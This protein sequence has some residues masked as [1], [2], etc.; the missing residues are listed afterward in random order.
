MKMRQRPGG[1]PE[2]C[3]LL[4]RDCHFGHQVRISATSC[5]TCRMFQNSFSFHFAR[6]A[7]MCYTL[8]GIEAC[9]DRRADEPLTS[10]AESNL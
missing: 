1:G 5:K 6:Q 10:Q 2:H 8:S 9:S 4:R 7:F 3:T